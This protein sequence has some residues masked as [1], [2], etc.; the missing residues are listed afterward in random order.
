MTTSLVESTWNQ[1]EVSIEDMDAV[2]HSLCLC[3]I[4][5]L[6]VLF[7]QFL[8]LFHHRNQFYETLGK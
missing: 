1:F 7:Q 4:Y 6:I 2:K 3:V 5:C 8:F